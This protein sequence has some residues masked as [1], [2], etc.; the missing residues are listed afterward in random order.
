MVTIVG[1]GP[2]GP[3]SCPPQAIQQLKGANMRIHAMP[4]HDSFRWLADMGLPCQAIGPEGAPEGSVLVIPALLE[5]SSQNERAKRAEALDRLV[6]TMDRLLGPGGCPWDQEQT[7][8]SL[9]KY[10]LEEA[11]EVLDAIDSGDRDKLK[12]ELGDLLLQPIF[13]AQMER[14]DGHFDIADVANGIT[15]K[16]IRRHPHVF[17]DTSVN[18]ADEVLRNWDRI[19]QKEKAGEPKSILAGVPV[20]MASLLRAHE[21]SKRAARVGFEWPDIEAVFDKLH[22]EERELHEALSSKDAERIE[23]EIGDLLFTAV[24]IARWAKIEPEEA[25]RKMLNRFTARFMEM[26]R[27]SPKPLNELSPDEWDELWNRAKAD[28]GR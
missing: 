12:E 3:E 10:L 14:R 9:K 17:G 25:L 21:I 15:E 19:K 8:E 18:D 24:N 7:H 16:L 20:G 26:E 11:Y 4:W 23:S 22:E 27:V 6:Q 5:E 2:A 13:H 28:L 1:V